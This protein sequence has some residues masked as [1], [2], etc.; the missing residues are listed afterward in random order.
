M[1]VIREKIAVKGAPDQEVTLKLTRHGPVIYEDA[2]KRRAFAIRSVWSEPGASAY[3]TS[4]ACINA[5]SPQEYAD[6]LRGWVAPSLNHVYADSDGNTAW[7][8]AGRAPVRPN[9][10][11]LLPVPGDGRYEWSGFTRFEDLPREVNP[12]KGYFATANE[13][14]IPPGHPALGKKLGF[15]WAEWSRTRRI[16]EVLDTQ[17]KH[18]IEQSMQLQADD[19]SIPARRMGKIVA[20]MQGT[21][22]IARALDL[23][24]GWDHHLARDSAAAALWEVSVGEA[25]A[26]GAVRC[27]R[28]GRRGTRAPRARR[29]PSRCSTC[30]KTSVCPT[31]MRSSRA[32]SAPRWPTAASAWATM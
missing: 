31:G 22:D 13:M 6:A 2:A 25:P 21:G 20:S 11:G 8:V 30:S 23:L 7:F 29:Y 18:T 3:F 14:N 1:E 5:K 10:D 27:A 17:P 9:W 15:E 12:A 16:H 24:R 32:R 26:A 4:I 28:T 19:L